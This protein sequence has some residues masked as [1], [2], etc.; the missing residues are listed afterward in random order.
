MPV[1]GGTTIY[2]TVFGC[3]PRRVGVALI[4]VL[5]LAVGTAI[6]LEL[7][8]EALHEALSPLGHSHPSGP[9]LKLY[10]NFTC[11]HWSPRTFE[12]LM[13]LYVLLGI[14][15]AVCLSGLLDRNPT[16]IR[17]FGVLLAA[18]AAGNPLALLG[19]CL[20]VQRCDRLPELWADLLEE[21][22]PQRMGRVRLMGYDSRKVSVGDIDGITRMS[23]VRRSVLL[24]C[25]KAVV[26]LYFAAR[27]LQL[28]DR[29]LDG[30]CGGPVYNIQVAGDL[31]RE[32]SMIRKAVASGWKYGWAEARG[33]PTLAPISN[34]RKADR[35]QYLAD[36]HSPA[37]VV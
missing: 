5:Y 34:L 2:G 29:T 17:A 31:A 24:I 26:E 19:D 7:A 23:T 32:Y 36:G 4:A 22:F 25:L 30:P 12:A 18:S 10:E 16:H 20:Y 11:E 3:L 33:E 8:Y 13:G 28:A 1:P 14:G 9:G 27:T 6:T 21:A 15:G 35:G 37:I